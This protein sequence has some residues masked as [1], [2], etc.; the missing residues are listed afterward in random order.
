MKF[1]RGYAELFHQLHVVVAVGTRLNGLRLVAYDVVF[2][3][4]DLLKGSYH[5]HQGL[6]ERYFAGGVCGLGS[7]DDDLSVF[8]AVIF[9]NI[10]SL[11][12][13]L[14]SQH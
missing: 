10:D 4:D 6:V 13:A 9:E 3:V 8:G 7:I 14:H 1:Q 12:R 11:H 2:V 5:C